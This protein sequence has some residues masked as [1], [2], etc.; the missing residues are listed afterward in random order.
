MS[1][2]YDSLIT[3]FVAAYKN[4]LTDIKDKNATTF[5]ESSMYQID[6]N[7][8]KNDFDNLATSINDLV[9][10]MNSIKPN[11]ERFPNT[12]SDIW[13]LIKNLDGF[14][15]NIDEISENIYIASSEVFQNLKNDFLF[16]SFGCESTSGLLDEQFKQYNTYSKQ[17]AALESFSSNFSQGQFGSANFDIEANRS[18]YKGKMNDLLNSIEKN[19]KVLEDNIAELEEILNSGLMKSA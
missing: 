11:E 2:R 7:L 4:Y 6:I 15:V 16:A 18:Y 9:E 14:K 3:R 12:C 19:I 8:V 1:N 17:L 10:S 13:Q 5:E